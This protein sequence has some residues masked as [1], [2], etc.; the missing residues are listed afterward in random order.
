ML[1]KELPLG[2]LSQEAKPLSWAGILGR[3]T[4]WLSGSGAWVT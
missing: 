3:G 1:E 4:T 2:E